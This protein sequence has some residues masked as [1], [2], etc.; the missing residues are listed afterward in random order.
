MTSTRTTICDDEW[1]G[2]V[3]EDEIVDAVLRAIEEW[4]EDADG[5]SG[6]TEEAPA[7]ASGDGTAQVEKPE[8][9]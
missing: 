1:R 3:V 7:E 9:P 8:L 6:A 4:D 2:K 5:T